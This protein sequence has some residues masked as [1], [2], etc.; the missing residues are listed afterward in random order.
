MAMNTE[1]LV[2]GGGITGLAV[3]FEL[4]RSGR[5]VALYEARRI[6]AMASG[7]TLGGIRQSGRHP[8]ELPLAR[9][10]VGLWGELEGR[11]GA[12]TGYR[13]TGN[14]RLAR[15][16]AEAATI[17][18]M[19]RAQRAL[20]LEI[21]YLA[22]PKD[23]GALAPGLGNGVL[24]A[25]FCPSDGQAEPT[26]VLTA[27]VKALR[28][29]GVAIHEA[30]PARTVVVERGRVNGIET[31]GG[32]V[33]APNVVLAAGIDSNRL[34][35][36][37]GL[38]VPLAIPEVVGFRTL[39]RP[40]R[41]GPVIGVANAEIAFRQQTDGSFRVTG[42]A[43]GDAVAGRPRG[44]RLGA[45][46]RLLDAFSALFPEA[47]DVPLAESWIG[48]LDQTPDALPVIEACDEPRGLVLAFG[49][50]GHGFA[51]GPIV[52]RLVAEMVA[53]RSPELSVEAFR[54]DRFGRQGSPAGV[55]LHG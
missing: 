33:A 46:A 50:S 48:F 23:I 45:L 54:R 38:A 44:P 4:A 53:G 52:G 9:A 7:A 5:R 18:R 42:A 29:L 30:E 43:A 40:P 13:R 1:V 51:L 6:G 11:L 41:L 15:S 16:A 26:A 3:A 32:R 21:D 47:A 36:P 34:L 14:L 17:L 8:A 19:V 55:T 25:S 24:A 22:D 27:Y 37:L 12:P 10:A 49:F 31:G 35:A 28:R 39:P 2:I 20:G